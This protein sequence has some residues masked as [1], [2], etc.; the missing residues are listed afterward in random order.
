MQA[1]WCVSSHCPA[2]T[3]PVLHTTTNNDDDDDHTTQVQELFLVLHLL[4]KRRPR[5][6]AVPAGQ[7]RLVHVVR[8]PASLQAHLRAGVYFCVGVVSLLPRR[9]RWLVLLARAWLLGWIVCERRGVCRHLR[10]HIVMRCRAPV[11][12]ASR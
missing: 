10:V 9:R 3:N 6:D 11:F 2:P 8:S 4:P 5:A 7:Q 1:L 12:V